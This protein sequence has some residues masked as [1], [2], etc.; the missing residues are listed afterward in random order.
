MC[1]IAGYHCASGAA[2]AV[3]WGARLAA[4]I[5]VLAHRGP[6]GAG[7]F[8]DDFAGLGHRRLSIIDRAGGRQPIA[9]EDGSI[10]LVC[11]GEI[12]NHA[13]L[14]ARLTALGHR[15]RCR[16]DSETVVH[17]YEQWGERCLEELRGMF[18]LALWDGPRRRLLLARDRLGKKPLYYGHVGGALVFASEI[19]ALA[20]LT[21][22][23]RS[24]DLEALSDYLSL[25]YVPR[26]K[27]IHRGVRKLL[28]GHLLLA[29]EHGVRVRRYWDLDFAA[30]APDDGA[31]ARLLEL[32]Q[33]AVA[34]RL[35][36][37]VPVGAFLS[38]GLDS[39]AVVA[40]MARSSNPPVVA[41]SIGFDA[42]AFD[43]RP[44]ARAAAA[45]FGVEH[46]DAVLSPPTP[47]L[48]Q[49]IAWHFDE[50]F[51]DASAV[52]THQL[53]RLSRRWMGVALGGDGGDEAFAGYRRYAFDLRENR[54]RAWL[55]GVV[56]RPLFGFLGRAYPKADRL[57]R[58]LRARTFLANLAREPWEAYLHSVGVMGEE[59]KQR[60]LAGDVRAAVGRYRTADLFAELWHSPAARDPLAR[61]QYVDLKTWLPDDILTK[62]DRACM[63]SALEVRSPLLDQRVV[64]YAATLPAD[65]KLRGSR[66]KLALRAAVGALLPAEVLRRP[67]V[68]FSMPV[69]DWLRG[70]LRPLVEDEVLAAPHELFDRGAVRALWR[71]HLA[72][73]RDHGAE[74]W[75]LLAFNLWHRRFA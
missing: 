58:P 22:F 4:M 73:G 55:P 13:E 34:V 51:G 42:P 57:P 14:R 41:I 37:E 5:A 66:S 15:F 16:S 30:A 35:Q 54:L 10:H 52:P 21:G 25:L 29:D 32:L 8:A 68:G 18:A 20:T 38:G 47:E 70:P 60:L 31:A 72:G 40:L 26:E 56:R 33:E 43:E 11:D 2:A 19:K 45:H 3:D 49:E 75:G 7:T 1:A 48:L 71:Q 44:Y 17:A 53:A 36:S 6:D 27:S 74:L 39:T 61:I 46:R 28:P 62:V 59:D 65:A 63:A 67:K 24:I 23:D 12:Y 64:E 9:N 50:P 69:S